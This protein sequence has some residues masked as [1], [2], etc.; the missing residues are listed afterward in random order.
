MFVLSVSQTLFYLCYLLFLRNYS[1]NA[2]YLRLADSLVYVP[3]SNGRHLNFKSGWPAFLAC[4]LHKHFL[5][6]LLDWLLYAAAQRQV[7]KLLPVQVQLAFEMIGYGEKCLGEDLFFGRINSAY[8]QENLQP[9]K[10]V[11]EEE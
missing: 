6:N 2:L 7:K 10:I 5:V 3:G 8:E 1:N 9:T 4:L 11:F